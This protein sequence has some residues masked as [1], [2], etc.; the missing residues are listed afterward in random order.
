MTLKQLK[1]KLNKDAAKVFEA[2]GMKCEVFSDNIYSTCPVHGGDN[3]RGFSFSPHRGVWRCWTR[4]CQN[5]HSSD[6]IGLIQAV[7]G[8]EGSTEVSF[9]DAVLWACQT[10]QLEPPNFKATSTTETPE[11]EE[12]EDEILE[13]KV[14]KEWKKPAK[15]VNYK[16]ETFNIDCQLDFP[17]QYFVDRGYEADTMRHFDVG[18]CNDCNDYLRD[19]AIIPIHDDSGENVVGIIGRAVKEYRQPKFLF[20][21]KGFD[22]RYLFY[23]WHRAIKH[24]LDNKIPYLYITEGQGDVWRLYEAGVKNAVS[25]FGK[26]ISQ[27]QITKLMSYPQISNLII[28]TDDDQAGRTSKIAISRQ[29]Q[30]THRLT[31]PSLSNKDVGNMSPQRIKETILYNLKGTY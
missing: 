13:N 22:K 24:I 23:N 6:I 20:H 15:E 10:F 30:R 21:P 3:P 25:I 2:L 16:L 19:R 4:E 11:N 17:S 28:L 14:L 26:T 29:L 12:E 9:K 1:V 31:F 18:D 8:Q 5:D 27:Q 7:L